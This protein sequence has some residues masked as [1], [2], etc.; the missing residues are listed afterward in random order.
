MWTVLIKLVL[1]GLGAVFSPRTLALLVLG[2]LALLGSAYGGWRYRDTQASQ[3][4]SEAVQRAVAQAQQ[5]WAVDREILEDAV[6]IQREVVTR[7]K[8]IEREADHAKATDC[9]DLG[10]DWVRVYNDAIR[11]TGHSTGATD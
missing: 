10:A 8:Y 7:F 9:R 3:Q 1:G 2:S 4:H 11:A 5:Q 6:Q